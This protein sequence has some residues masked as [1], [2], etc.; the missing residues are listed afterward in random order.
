MRSEATMTAPRLR[1]VDP[2]EVAP[3]IVRAK[4]ERSARRVMAMLS[5]SVAILTVVGL[6]MVLSASSITAFAQFGSS[7]TFFKK[8][9]LYALLGTGAAAATARLRYQV[10]QRVWAPLLLFTGFLLVV[11]LTSSAA[12]VAGGS[13]RWI[14]VGGFSMQ[15]SELAKFSIVV[16]VAVILSRHMKHLDEQAR[17]G[18]PILGIVGVFGGLIL[19][20]PDLGTAMLIALTVFV[21]L[22]VAGVRLRT[23]GLSFVLSF[24]AGMLLILNEGYRRTRFLSFLHP[25]QDPRNTGYQIVQSL[26]ALGSGHLFGVGLGASR[27]KWMYVPNAHTDFIFSIMGEEL[28]LIGEIVVLALFVTLIFAGIRIA[29]KAP[30]TFGRLLAAGI[31]AWL[32]LQAIVNVGGATGVLP[33]TGVPLPFVSFGGSSLIVSLGAVGVL[34]SIGRAEL[35]A[36]SS[37]GGSARTAASKGASARRRGPGPDRE[38]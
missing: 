13:A 37:K 20:Q 15:P 32:G 21:L 22:F 24:G 38:K 27:Q 4:A 12:V 1:V 19:I 8:Q 10:W 23:L 36:A 3:R 6:V 5:I 30:D 11:V 31:T 7:F 17:W 14:Q 28:G 9:A 18:V 25:W 26:I 16:A 2:D 35:A 33:I 34:F 29:M